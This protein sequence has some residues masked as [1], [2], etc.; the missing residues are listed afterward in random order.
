[1]LY[2]LTDKLSFNDDPQVEIKGKIIT[3]KSDAETVLKLLDIVQNGGEIAGT[4]S[5]VDLLLSENDKKTL[6]GL[7]LK[8][9]DYMK[10]TETIV[11]LALGNDPDEDKSREQ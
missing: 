11:D 10:F 9:A 6:K 7:N 5:A 8:I 1:M 2:S 4:V 3:V